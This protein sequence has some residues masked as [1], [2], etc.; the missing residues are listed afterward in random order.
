MKKSIC[1]A[2]AVRYHRHLIVKFLLM[3]LFI[4]CL[5][6]TSLQ[7]LAFNSFSQKRIN[8][9]L[10]NVSIAS[11]LDKIEAKYNYRFLY[12]ENLKLGNIKIDV[13]AKDATLD[14]VLHQLLQSTFFSYK[15]INDNLLVIASGSADQVATKTIRGKIFNDKREPLSGASIIEKGTTNGTT[16]DANGSFELNVKD[17]NSILIVSAIGYVLQE[18]SVKGTNDLSIALTPSESKMDEV[19]VVGY[20][21]QRKVNLTGSVATVSA[22][23]IE[24][25]PMTNISAGLAGLL[26]G[27]YARQSTGLPGGD[28]ATI[29]VRG[30]GTLNNAGPMVLVDG[31]ESSMNDINPEDIATISV[32]KDAASA[33]IYGSKAANG[34]ILITTKTG[35]KGKPIITFS[36]N[37]GKQTATR[38]P[39]YLSSADYAMLYNEA[40]AFEGRALRFTQE[41]IQKFRDGSDPVGHPN[42]DWLDLLYAGKGA[43][44][45]NT[46]TVA[47][48][49]ENVNYMTSVNYQNQKGIIKYT[50]KDQYGAR[51]NLTIKPLSWIETGFNMSFTREAQEQPN[52]A[53]V[54]GGL[55]QT[56]RQVN[57]IAPWIPYK[58]ADGT[59]GTISDGNPIA[60][61][62][63]GAQINRLRNYFLGIGSVTL[64]PFK[65]FSIKGVASIKTY[66]ED[67]NEFRKE[68]Q[69]NP[70][71]YHGPTRMNQNNTADE[72]RVGE[73]IANYNTT[74][75]SDHNI[76]VMAGYH[77]ELYKYKTTTAYRQNFPSTELTDL[78]GGATD[79]M[80]N[81][82][83]TRELSML[84][85]FGRVNYAFRGKYLLEMNIRRDGSSRFATNNR[86]G[87]FPSMSV[88]WRISQESFFAPLLNTINDLKVRASWGK[89][90]NQDALTDYYPAIPTLSLGYD[91]PF[92]SAINSGAAIVDARNTAI[93]WEEATT[94]GIGVDFSILKKVTVNVDYYK[95]LTKGIIM[96]VPSPE[97]FALSNFVDNIGRMENKGVEVNA[98]YNDKYGD[99]GFNFGV[100]FAYNKNELLELAG[101]TEI[102]NGN[103]IR[104]VGESVDAFYGYKTDGIFKTDAEAAAVD[105]RLYNA[106]T[107][108]AGDLKYVD[109][110]GDGKVDAAD[111]VILGNSIPPVN[112]GFNFGATYKNFDFVAIFNG[113]L[114]GYGYM[115]FDAVGGINGDAQKPAALW[116]DR[117]TPENPNASVPRVRTGINGPNMPQNNVLSYW[118][119]SSNYLRLKNIQVGYNFANEYL[120]SKG[121]RS[122]RVF[123]SS[124]NTFTITKFLKGWDP[125]APSGRGSGYP[126]VMVNAV[127]VNIS[128]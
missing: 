105:N 116:L 12:D 22:D 40:L 117:W 115:N 44:S 33:S 58:N 110:N 119:R 75:N 124:Q 34:V 61:I 63:Q 15:K 90:G 52:N 36:S 91:Y 69:Y 114:G 96:A 77:A 93:T 101:Q 123:F 55:D 8:L 65:D 17:E 92:N 14:S 25:R 72:R 57:R 4:A 113:T 88:G 47:G 66:T 26:P 125:E 83:Y 81:G 82:G 16:T 118:L 37:L 56:I 121:I 1:Q 7:G 39:E 13:F 23:K 73:V 48:G 68:I 108:K 95:R 84:S 112:F 49:A 21:T 79:G 3:K 104:R 122:A 10:K 87:T 67:Y 38:L 80:Q 54:G 19:V 62:D 45:I 97:T 2:R 29:R 41:D 99:V 46:V 51:T 78:N 42:T 86:W 128:F 100:N 32:L 64:K 111:R 5:L 127:G 20:G 35:K 102:I 18:V 6:F 98:Q 120:K 70:N 71:K 103:N 109:A 60:W 94:T 74:I 50:G 126:V 107:F 11:V 30:V 9:D 76:G 85:Y 24:G 106:G 89:L 27:V 53:Y 28:G 43:Q 59:Y 31:I